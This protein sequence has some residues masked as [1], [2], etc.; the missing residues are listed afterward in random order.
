MLLLACMIVNTGCSGGGVSSDAP[1][2]DSRETPVQPADTAGALAGFPFYPGTEQLSE[3]VEFEWKNLG[4]AYAVPYSEWA[5]YN[6][7]ASHTD[8]AAFYKSKSIAPPFANISLY[9]KETEKG[10][11]GAWF[12]ESSANKYARIWFIPNPDDDAKSYLII[13]RNNDIGSCS[14][15]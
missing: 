7:H 8:V 6:V 14:I 11:L 15:F 2:P 4:T 5:Y 1:L 10:V 9:W 12:Q 13:M 3:P